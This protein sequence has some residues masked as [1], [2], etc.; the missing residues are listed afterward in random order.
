MI[1]NQRILLSVCIAFLGSQQQEHWVIL[2]NRYT[3]AAARVAPCL[4]HLF[5]D[6]NPSAAIHLQLLRASFKLTPFLPVSF[7]QYV[8]E[9]FINP[10]T[11][12]SLA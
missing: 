12:C 2:L 10:N 1:E 8:F 6:R 3:K 5:C 9:R 4:F 7:H 11:I